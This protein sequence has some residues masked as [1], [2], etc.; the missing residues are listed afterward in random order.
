MYVTERSLYVMKA[1]GVACRGILD[2][3]E[4]SAIA[5]VQ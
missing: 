5:T 2:F 1:A 4:D 3:E